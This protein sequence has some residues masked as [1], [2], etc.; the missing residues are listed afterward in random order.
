MATLLFMQWSSSVLVKEV[1]ILSCFDH[2][3]ECCNLIGLAI[4][5]LWRHRLFYLITYAEELQNEGMCGGHIENLVRFETLNPSY[6][7]DNVS[8]RL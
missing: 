8:K 6:F 4:L 2:V 1:K 7:F 5:G 3:I